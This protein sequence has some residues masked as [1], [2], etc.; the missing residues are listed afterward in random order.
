M[1]ACVRACVCVRD[2]LI[3]IG[4]VAKKYN[5]YSKITGSQR[6]DLFGAAV[7]QLP[8]I[9]KELIDA[10]LESGAAYAKGLRMVKSCVGTTWC[11][12]GIGDSVGFAVMLENRYK[13][14]RS[15]HKLK[16]AVSG[17]IRE[18]AEAQSKDFGMIA[19]EGG[20]NI[21]VC[22][23]G[24]V[25]P[26]HA[27]LL[28]EKVSEELTVK[29]LDRFLMYYILTA[30]K[31]QR[32]APWLEKLEGGI[33]HLKDVVIH[34]KL[35]ICDELEARM[36]KLINSYECEWKAVT[37]DPERIAHFKQFVNTTDTESGLTL[38]LALYS[39]LRL[40]DSLTL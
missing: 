31:L 18:C 16:S 30:D 21:Y 1:R 12:Y 5:L 14:I 10:G 29:Y 25:K 15:P 24:G 32:T 8:D 26:R 40:S 3:A 9:W 2:Q 34:D 11:R 6:V 36:A 33:E 37:E 13:G 7:H 38:S 39:F 22:G 28:A 20:F 19:V 4:N 35:G 23:N 17:C 27:T